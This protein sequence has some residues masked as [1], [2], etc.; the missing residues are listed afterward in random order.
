[1]I[2]VYETLLKEKSKMYNRDYRS[3]MAYLK[4]S[5]FYEEPASG[6]YHN[7]FPGGLAEHC[8]NLYHSLSGL[9]EKI[10]V[11]LK[12]DEIFDP[13]IVA[14]GHDLNKVGK[15]KISQR[16]IKDD[17]GR[18]ESVSYYDYNNDISPETSFNSNLVCLN[19]ITKYVDCSI[20]EKLAVY[21]AEG[22]WSAK[23]SQ[24]EYAA[25]LKSDTRIYYTHVADMMATYYMESI[26]TPKE[27]HNAINKR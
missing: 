13:L 14:I 19:I 22:L 17:S 8:L 4:S 3:L 10:G 7:N 2:E 21:W 6:R 23:E 27:V 26:Y 24:R 20:I 25:A 11:P 15:Y 18:W 16:N 9:I 1:M 12:K 5:T